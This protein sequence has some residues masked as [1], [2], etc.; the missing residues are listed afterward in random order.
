METTGAGD[1]SILIGGLDFGEGPR[2]HDGRLWY[3]DFYRHGVFAVTTEGEREQILELDDHPSGLGW[4]PDGRLLFVAMKSRTVRRREHDGSISVHADLSELAGGR[5]ND[6]V[7]ATDGTAYVGNFGSDVWSGEPMRPAV[8]ARVRPDGAVDAVA[9]DLEFPNGTVI[10]P[11]GRTL[12]VG[13]SM[14]RR[15]TAFDLLPDGTLANRRIWAEL[16]GIGPDGC[17]LDADGAIW[18]ADALGGEVVRVREGGEIT[19][20]V[21]AGQKAYA[22]ALGGTDGRTLFVVCA[23]SPREEDAAGSGTG[24]IRTTRVAVPHAGLP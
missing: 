21:D 16:P 18:C 10:T 3:S 14:G 9:D 17:T 7:V 22:C 1:V 8:L 23:D 24:T 6:M 20:R 2:W 15:Y 5:C 4:L 19:D 12:I 13:E 11:D